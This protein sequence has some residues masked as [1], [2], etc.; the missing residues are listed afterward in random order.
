MLQLNENTNA[1]MLDINDELFQQIVDDAKRATLGDTRLLNAL[2]RAV[3]MLDGNPYVH[4]DGD[5]LLV[6]SDT[7]LRTYAVNNDTCQCEAFGRGFSCKHQAAR[8][9]LQRYYEAK[10]R[11]EMETDRDGQVEDAVQFDRPLP[12]PPPANVLRFTEREIK[13]TGGTVR[14]RRC[15]GIQY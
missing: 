6:M 10:A 5:E 14:D 9:L 1:A 15:G 11:R 4:V 13:T 8:R 12:P 7:S 3:T 2:D